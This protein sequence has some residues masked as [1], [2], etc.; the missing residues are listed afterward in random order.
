MAKSD[1]TPNA[2]LASESYDEKFDRMKK[3]K[4]ERKAETTNNIRS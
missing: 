4:E 2:K 3:R 1:T